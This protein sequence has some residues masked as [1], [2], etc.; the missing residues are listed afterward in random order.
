V[1][2]RN[3]L[4]NLGV[5]F[6]AGCLGAFFNSLAVWI[7]GVI[8]INA[9]LGLSINPTLS[10]KWLYPRIVWGGIWG[11][12]YILFKNLEMKKFLKVF[13]FSLAPTLVQ[14]LIVFPLK[15]QK[16]FFGVDLG[17][18]TPLLVVIF[19]LVWAGVAVCFIDC[20]N[21]ES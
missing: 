5:F 4:N 3:C 16:G 13:L 9:M 18:M 17:V 20:A 6:S 21:G 7:F 8:G 11:L 2:K 1:T 10:A 19:N 12:S 15:A 14:L